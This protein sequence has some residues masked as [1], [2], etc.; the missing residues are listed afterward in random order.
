MASISIFFYLA[1]SI[2]RMQLFQILFSQVIYIFPDLSI[3][4]NN[5]HIC[6]HN[7][8]CQNGHYGH[9]DHFVHNG[10]NQYGHYH[11]HYCCLLKD[12]EKCRSPVKRELKKLQLVKSYG[13]IKINS[14]IMAISFVFWADFS[15][16]LW[17]PLKC[18]DLSQICFGIY[19]Y[20][21]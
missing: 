11:G 2:D 15:T 9:F 5:D 7:I 3:D 1:I 19:S 18:S 4:T 14:E 10:L 20:I 17:D 16:G 8:P 6:G 12:Q 13:R 21:V